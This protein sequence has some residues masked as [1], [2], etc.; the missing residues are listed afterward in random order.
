MKEQPMDSCLV[1]SR[2]KYGADKIVKFLIKSNIKAE[3]IHGNKS[4]GARQRALNNFKDGKTKVLVATDIAARGIDVE[5]L[6]VV[7]NFDLPNIPETY[8]HRIGRTGRASAS[9]LAISFCDVEERAFLK[10]IQNLIKQNI[11]VIDDN[12]FID[13]SPASSAPVKKQ[14]NRRPTSSVNNNG[15]KVQHGY[16]SSNRR[17][18]KRRR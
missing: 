17:P 16:G 6:S 10:D 7:I 4:Q 11:P 2:T 8:V 12:P 1:F 15:G 18:N 3:A 5:D 9:G 13:E 14:K